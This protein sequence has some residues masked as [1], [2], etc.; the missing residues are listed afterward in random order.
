MRCRKKKME[1]QQSC[2]YDAILPAYA[3]FF[4][5]GLDGRERLSGSNLLVF[6]YI[7]YSENLLSDTDLVQT[8]FPAMP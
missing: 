1:L 2:S 3:L 8:L 4:T 5:S 7:T 6:F